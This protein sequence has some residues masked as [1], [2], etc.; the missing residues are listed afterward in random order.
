MQIRDVMT[1][2]PVT[3]EPETL[4]IDAQEIM[5]KHKVRR[6][7]VVENQKLVGMITHDMVL[8]ASPSQG[9]SLSIY[10]LHFILAKMKVKDI[11]IKDPKTLS[12]DTPLE[13][14]LILSQDLG[15]RAF[16]VVENGKLL[17]ITTHGDILRLLT[18][19]LGLREEGVRITI[20]GLGG[21]LGELKDIISI[22]DRH[23]AAVMSI[24][25]LPKEEQKDWV[26]VIRLKVKDGTAILED[27]RKVGLQVKYSDESGAS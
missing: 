22:F 1:R 15:I 17:G 14:S 12:P 19:A 25:T 21:R 5:R 18:R 27:L 9:T 20:E 24:M 7:P 11:M 4:L 6:L 16:P 26:A 8:E 3:V 10:E 13:K 23:R 2:D